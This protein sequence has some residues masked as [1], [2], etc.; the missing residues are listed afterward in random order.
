MHVRPIAHNIF[1]PHFGSL[2]IQSFSKYKEFQPVNICYSGLYNWWYTIGIRSNVE[3]FNGAFFLLL[4][5]FLF[6]FASWLHLQPSYLPSVSWFKS[7]ESRLNHHLSGLF[8][9]SSLA[10]SGHLVHVAIPESR[11][12]NISWDNYLTVFP[13][14]QGLKPFY[15]L[16][17]F[18]YSENSDSVDHIFGT[19][20]GAGTAI[21]TFLG[22][23]H[24]QTKSL[25]LSDIAHH[26]LAIV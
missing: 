17:W 2:A 3:L 25:W 15:T 13:F 18:V 19:P 1:D 16:N 6:L 10:W 12:I 5:S 23:F 7:A 22:G 11:G 24:P 8:G 4:V 14:P 9:L 26:H 21:L 20:D